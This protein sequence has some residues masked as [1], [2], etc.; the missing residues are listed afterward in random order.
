[1]EPKVLI[2]AYIRVFSSKEGQTVID[3]LRDFSGVDSADGCAL[4]HEEYAY[5]AGKRDM[6]KY[7]E[8]LTNGE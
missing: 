1:M 5:R 3:D 6:F 7:I 8:A 2:G 4:T